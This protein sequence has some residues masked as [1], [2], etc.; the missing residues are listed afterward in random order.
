MVRVSFSYDSEDIS[1][2]Q[3]RE[4]GFEIILKAEHTGAVLSN[5]YIHS[6]RVSLMVQFPRVF[7]MLS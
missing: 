4:K 1:Y 3:Q 5:T 6:R 2:S 7:N